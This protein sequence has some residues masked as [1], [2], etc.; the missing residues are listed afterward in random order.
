MG[1]K[2]GK[3]SDIRNRKCPECG[4]MTRSFWES[5]YDMPCSDCAEKAEETRQ[6]ERILSA[7]KSGKL[8]K[9][10]LTL[11]GRRLVGLV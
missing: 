4:L 9:S 1:V 5:E 8:V 11:R 2:R 10:D 3:M 6:R 7:L